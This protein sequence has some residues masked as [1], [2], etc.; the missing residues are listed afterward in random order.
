MVYNLKPDIHIISYKAIRQRVE[1][2]ASKC[3]V[4]LRTSVFRSPSIPFSLTL[5]SSDRSRHEI[6]GCQMN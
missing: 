3:C 1:D 5:V 6:R 2:A 4:S